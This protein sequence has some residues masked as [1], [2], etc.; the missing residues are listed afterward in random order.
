MNKITGYS[1]WSEIDT[2]HGARL[3]Y[4]IKQQSNA[5]E[6]FNDL[7]VLL[8]VAAR[9]NAGFDFDDEQY[10]GNIEYRIQADT[11]DDLK[12]NLEVFEKICTTWIERWKINEIEDNRK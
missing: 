3:E 9:E 10:C 5:D 11:L 6:I 1:A 4:V 8:C 12:E 7:W 2:K